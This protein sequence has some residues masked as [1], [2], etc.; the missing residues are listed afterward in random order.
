MDGVVANFVRAQSSFA[1]RCSIDY[2]R[3]VC[4]LYS[5][6]FLSLN[7]AE[8]P[9]RQT[10]SGKIPAF[11]QAVVCH[12]HQR[13]SLERLCRYIARPALSNERLSVNERGQVVY[14]LK[15]VFDSRKIKPVGSQ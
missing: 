12:P 13:D 3:Q 6:E 10:P 9:I 15:L 7:P 5:K 1:R 8:I 11:E 2:S 4:I 14:R